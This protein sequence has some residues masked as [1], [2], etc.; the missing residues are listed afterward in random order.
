MVVTTGSEYCMALTPKDI[1]PNA[2]KQPMVGIAYDGPSQRDQFHSH[3][4]AQ[5]L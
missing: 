4:S 5:L 2:L 3:S 1:D